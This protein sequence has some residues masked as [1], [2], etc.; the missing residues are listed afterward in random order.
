MHFRMSGSKGIYFD[1]NILEKDARAMRV[2]RK[3][4]GFSF[5]LAW[6][7]I[8]SSISV[9][10]ASLEYYRNFVIYYGDQFMSSS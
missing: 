2:A 5:S 7:S 3:L 4:L 9:G 1:I 10:N 6:S 8:T